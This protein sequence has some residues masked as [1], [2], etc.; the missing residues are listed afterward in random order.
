MRQA[1][2]YPKRNHVK[3]IENYEKKYICISLTTTSQDVF[4]N[5]KKLGNQTYC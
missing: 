2:L 1:K 3:K 4:Q 5:E